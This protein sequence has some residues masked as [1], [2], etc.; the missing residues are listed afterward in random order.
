MGRTAKLGVRKKKNGKYFL[1]GCWITDPDRPGELRRHRPVFDTKAEAKDEIA[2][3]EKKEFEEGV[4]A[5]R[6]SD[7]E[8]R[9]AVR[10]KDILTPFH[11]TLESAA[12]FYVKHLQATQKSI[13]F[14]DLSDEFFALKKKEMDANVDGAWTPEDYR[15]TKS[16]SGK[17][18]ENFKDRWVSEISSDDIHNWLEDQ[19]LVCGAQNR[20]N[21]RRALSKIFAYAKM[22]KYCAENTV[23]SVNRIRVTRERPKVF[24][25]DQIAT[26]L[27]G[28]PEPLRPYIAIGVFAGLRPSEVQRLLW[29]DIC[30]GQ[31]YV[32]KHGKTGSRYA[33]V[34][35]NLAVWLQPFE[36]M[37]GR[38]AVPEADRKASK[39]AKDLKVIAG[40]WPQDILRHSFGTAHLCHFKNEALTAHL[41]GNSVSVI[42]RDYLDAIPKADAARWWELVPEPKGCPASGSEVSR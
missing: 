18:A 38:V 23:S 2:K 20:K 15:D 36:K 40:K 16:R 19:K 9:D 37:I 11:A 29:S 31:I 14:K 35:P 6:L 21:H 24:T 41:M 8:R 1:T 7:D 30:N 32:N 3:I 4:G 26:L 17:F 33:S 13:L 10:A 42:K 25:V 12:R 39:L 27:N 34:E 28:A 5:S 22:K